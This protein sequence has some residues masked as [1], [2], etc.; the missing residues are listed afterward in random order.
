MSLVFVY[1]ILQ[2]RVPEDPKDCG[3]HVCMV[4]RRFIRGHA[5][6]TRW[7]LHIQ[8]SSDGGGTMQPRCSRAQPV[9]CW[10]DALCLAVVNECASKRMGWYCSLVP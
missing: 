4:T 9:G 8:L 2:T 1:Q 7:N 6:L 5:T 10:L 3:C